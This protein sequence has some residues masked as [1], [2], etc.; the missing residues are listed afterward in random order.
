[1]STEAPPRKRKRK[2]TT[3]SGKK[4]KPVINTELS[5]NQKMELISNVLETRRNLMSSMDTTHD[6]NKECG[7]PVVLSIEDHQA[8][9]DREGLAARIVDVLPE[10]SF[11]LPPEIA[12]NES[13]TETAF[14]KR[15]AELEKAH[16]L[17]HYLQRI[18][19]LSGV[20]RFGVLLIGYDDGLEL[21]EPIESVVNQKHPGGEH[22][23]LFLKPIP[24]SSVNIADYETDVSNPRFGKPLT[25]NIDFVEF[26]PTFKGQ[27][28]VSTSSTKSVHWSRVHHVAD[29][30]GS[31]DILGTPRLEK[32]YNRVFD[33]RKILSGSGEMFW[34]GAFPGLAF[35]MDSD[36][37]PASIDI[38]GMKEEIEK[39]DSGMQR[40]LKLLGIKVNSLAPQV[41]DP[42]SHIKVNLEVIAISVGCPM[43]IL[44][45]SE[46]AKL[47]STQD[48]LTWNR[49]IGRRQSDYLST[50]LIRPF[51]QQLIYMGVLPEADFKI[52]WPDLNTTDDKTRAEIALLQATAMGEYVMKGGNNI[53]AELE[54]FTEVMGMDSDLALAVLKATADAMDNR[55]PEE[56]AEGLTDDV[57]PSTAP[58]KDKK[59]TKKTKKEAGNE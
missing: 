43:R 55:E 1:M 40:Y 35:E 24:E 29:N 45:G 53:M 28:A 50:M 48:M 31:S 19:K 34:K 47:A 18:D 9:Y 5:G 20:G 36:V 51:I 59:K 12:E 21:S 8:F 32:T 16:N 13:E 25:Y 39:Y 26:A 33:I 17:N 46:Q 2:P 42:S 22:E 57:R 23:I 54:F 4:K 6:I 27:E 41:A 49:R 14:E 58:K 52:T 15:L 56:D 11:A 37:D 30:R 3:N 44:F 10:E 38:E 7:Y